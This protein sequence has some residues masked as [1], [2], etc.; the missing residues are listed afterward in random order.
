MSVI[1]PQV[2]LPL[3]WVV[4]GAGDVRVQQLLVEVE[5]HQER[6]PR[7][8]AAYPVLAAAFSVVPT[9]VCVFRVARVEPQTIGS[10]CGGEWAK[11]DNA[12]HRFA[13]DKA[14]SVEWLRLLI[15]TKRI[16]ESEDSAAP[17]KPF[18]MYVLRCPPPH[19]CVR[20]RLTSVCGVC[21]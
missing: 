16:Q 10:R 8:P 14:G 20:V 12:Y 21:H 7:W 19:A 6:S 13:E 1:T 9:C 11:A 15:H 3:L 18:E 4:R 5:R 2:P 17:R